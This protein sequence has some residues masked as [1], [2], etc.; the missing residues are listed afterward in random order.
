MTKNGKRTWTTN[1]IHF[2][3]WLAL[4]K[5][6]RSPK[7]HG[8]LARRFGVGQDVLSNW[9]NLPGFMDEVTAKSREYLRS[10][11]PDV[12]GALVREAKSG[13]V[14]AIKLFAQLTDQL[15][16]RTDVTS[17]GQPIE[18]AWPKPPKD[19]DDTD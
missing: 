7:T 14:P 9:K 13:D 4:P 8:E 16:E 15:V 18:L 5:Q 11:I 19:D 3:E 1:Q 17:S 2:Q 12:F 6:L 10:E